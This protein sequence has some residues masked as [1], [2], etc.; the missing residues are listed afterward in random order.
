MLRYFGPF[1]RGEEGEGGVSFA[2]WVSFVLSRPVDAN[3]LCDMSAL[4]AL[5]W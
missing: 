3:L 1:M 4:F 5:L 2:W